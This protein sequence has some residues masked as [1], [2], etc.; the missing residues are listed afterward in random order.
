MPAALLFVVA[1]VLLYMYLK[2]M[3][4][5]TQMIQASNYVHLVLNRHTCDT[6]LIIRETPGN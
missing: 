1:V 4:F 5:F 3:F 2:A 6:F